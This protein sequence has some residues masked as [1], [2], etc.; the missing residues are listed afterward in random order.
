[1][2]RALSRQRQEARHSRVHD[3]RGAGAVGHNV[4][5][6]FGVPF[7]RSANEK[8]AIQAAPQGKWSVCGRVISYP[9]PSPFHGS[10]ALY[11]GPGDA[12]SWD[13]GRALA[14]HTRYGCCSAIDPQEGGSGHSGQNTPPPGGGGAF[15][16]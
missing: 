8:A 12:G 3:R 10:T 1:M 9:P 2:P 7:G 13:P 14:G 6:A 4:G 11:N 15:R 16:G 5:G